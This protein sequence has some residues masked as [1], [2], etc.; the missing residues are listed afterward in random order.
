MSPCLPTAKKSLRRINS[1]YLLFLD[2]EVIKKGRV[3]F[4]SHSFFFPV[5]LFSLNLT[6][7]LALIKESFLHC[8][9]CSKMQPAASVILTALSFWSEGL[10]LTHH[11]LL[12]TQLQ[13]KR[14]TGASGAADLGFSRDWCPW[15]IAVYKGLCG[16]NSV[17]KWL[18][19]HC[20]A[21]SVDYYFLFLLG[22]K[23]PEVMVLGLKVV[24]Y[25]N[26][27]FFLHW[28]FL[29]QENGTTWQM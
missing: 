13:H 28:C 23:V 16:S 3:I 12:F 15:L 20:L 2:K 7:V 9:T 8:W 26:N 24:A 27:I 10:L 17:D 6:P 18:P 5:S 4:T 21:K 25:S 14:F 29:L 11:S 1:L 22:L 19:S